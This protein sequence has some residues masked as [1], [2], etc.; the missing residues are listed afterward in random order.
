M[1]RR[2]EKYAPLPSPWRLFLI[3]L[4]V[5]FIIE[6][7]V[8]LVLPLLL[9]KEWLSL[10][11]AVDALLLII[12][13]TPFLWWLIVR[14]LRSTALNEQENTRLQMRRQSAL[15]EISRATTSTLDLNAVLNILMQ[16]IDLLLPDTPSSCGWSTERT[17]SR[18]ERPAG[19][20]LKTSGRVGS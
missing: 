13:S 17:G 4:A 8:M 12:L 16:K 5:V 3:V 1:R 19:T 15:Y 2:Y 20:C 18:S 7:S 9:P 14:P 11:P 10:A 6:A